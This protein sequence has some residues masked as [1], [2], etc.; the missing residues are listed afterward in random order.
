MSART[1]DTLRVAAVQLTASGDKDANIATAG[2]LVEQAAAA[3][4]QLVVLPEKWNLI[5]NERR[6]VAGGEP[7]DGRSLNAARGWAQARG[8]ALVAGSVSEAVPGTD[9]AYN[10][11]VLIQPDGSVTAIYRKLH[12]FDVAV[13]GHTYR[14][15]DGAVPGADIVVGRALGHRIGM[16]IC[17]DLRFPELF[18]ALTIAGAQI[19]TVP[20][21]F[22]ET[23][24]LA[25]WEPLLRARAIEN[26]VFVIAAGQIGT[27]ATG[28]A[29]HGHS[30]IIDPWGVILA[31]AADD[32][33]TILADLDFTELERI[34]RDLPALAHRRADLFDTAPVKQT[35]PPLG[36]NRLP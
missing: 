34:R 30:M 36:A 35:D 15:S 5:D 19:L 16:T 27:H 23:T 10:T 21:A 12:L 8:I 6:Q 3:G 22:T 29:S 25:H 32:Q 31:E 2:R 14:E 11:S 17:Y 28:T 26:Q 18:R 24:G 7:L 9:R 20:A 33:T 13:G 4:A 1:P